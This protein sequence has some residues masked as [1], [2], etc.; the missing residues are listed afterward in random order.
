MLRRALIITLFTALVGATPALAQNPISAGTLATYSIVKGYVTRAA[1]M[2]PEEGYGYQPTPEVRTFGAL[3][4]H[5]ADASFSICGG[6]GGQAPPRS[7][8]E[9]S[10]TGKAALREALAEGFAFCDGIY[11]GMTDARG[12]ETVPFMGGQQMARLSVLGFNT[13]HTFEHYGN[14]VTYMRL[15]GMVPPSSMPQ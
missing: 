4:A 15:Q 8:I 6:A 10:V 14:I 12:A 3:I 7:G 1:E 13:H 11:E 9:D 2:V 5:I